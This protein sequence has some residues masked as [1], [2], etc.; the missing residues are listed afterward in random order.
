MW[1]Q[2]VNRKRFAVQHCSTTRPPSNE[3]AAPRND[4][5][6]PSCLM[7]VHL[8]CEQ[9][10]TQAS[11]SLH[12]SSFMQSIRRLCTGIPHSK[13]HIKA[14][15]IRPVKQHPAQLCCWSSALLCMQCIC[16]PWPA[17]AQHEHRSHQSVAL[18]CRCIAVC[19]VDCAAQ[20]PQ[21]AIH[22]LLCERTQH[23][24]RYGHGHAL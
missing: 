23:A 12:R 1:L 14:T 20:G 7:C 18:L 11:I 17:C 15:A 16:R 21:H 9:G 19:S 5:P 13:Q 3:H 6:R 8:C 2:L 24:V 10:S 4:T 22:V